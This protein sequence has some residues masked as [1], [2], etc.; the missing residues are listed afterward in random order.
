M[1]RGGRARAAGRRH[2][3]RSPVRLRRRPATRIPSA[4]RLTAPRRSVNWSGL[5]R[6][7]S[8]G[9]DHP[10]SP[11]CANGPPA[12]ATYAPVRRGPGMPRRA[13]GWPRRRGSHL[14]AFFPRIQ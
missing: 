1:H 7:G 14:A 11:P 4:S 10:S 8:A 12:A 6:R 3:V 2:D 5:R 13:L 9:A